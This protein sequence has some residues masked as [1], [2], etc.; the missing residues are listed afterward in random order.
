MAWCVIGIGED[1]EKTMSQIEKQD[2]LQLIA[3][4]IL[5]SYA[6][7]SPYMMEITR[8]KTYR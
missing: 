1:A 4:L 5:F 8:S 7:Q 6:W 2:D 3:D